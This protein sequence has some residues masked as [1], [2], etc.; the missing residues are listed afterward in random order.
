M[1]LVTQLG[2]A[3]NYCFGLPNVRL[4]NISSMYCLHMVDLSHS[5]VDSL[6]ELDSATTE[7]S[8]CNDSTRF[9]EGLLS[10]AGT[11]RRSTRTSRPC[12]LLLVSAYCSWG[13]I[14]GKR[15]WPRT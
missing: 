11:R 8:A 5:K 15:L 14:F 3:I 12:T 4:C 2:M 1:P 6:I 13:S 7:S 9:A 10:L